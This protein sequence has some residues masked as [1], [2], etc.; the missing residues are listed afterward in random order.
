MTVIEYLDRFGY[1]ES[2]AALAIDHVTDPSKLT[3]KDAVVRAAVVELQQ[4]FE[5]ELNDLV[6][7]EHSRSLDINGDSGPATE[8]LI[9]HD[10]C[11]H[12]DFQMVSEPAKFPNSCLNISTSYRMSLNGLS[13]DQLQR[14]WVEADKNISDAINLSFT[15][16]LDE[17]PN[18][19]IYAFEAA[20]G[21]S[22]LADQY[23]S[24]GRCSDRLRG[25]FD[26]RRWN[27]V[28]FVTTCTHEHIHAAGYG[29]TND[30][31]ATSYPSIGEPAMRRRGALNGTDIRALL[32]LGYKRRTTPPPKPDDPKFEVLSTFQHKGET[33]RVIVGEPKDDDGGWTIG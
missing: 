25:R 29:H 8:K 1:F 23:L 18:T 21:G 22:V 31:N 5:H 6:W 26:N 16:K 2:P 14:L 32:S 28:L 20:L 4:F 24:Q 19:N 30:P 12:P 7:R 15:L 17:Y 11:G 10:R 3:M 27:E 33:L 9:T 13:D